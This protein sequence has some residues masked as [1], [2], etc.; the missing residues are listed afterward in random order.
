MD[1]QASYNNELL[2]RVEDISGNA[3][4]LFR[5]Q[6]L[7]PKQ[8]AIF[9][10]LETLTIYIMQPSQR[11][12]YI[13]QVIDALA[14]CEKF[15]KFGDKAIDPIKPHYSARHYSFGMN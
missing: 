15:I 6:Y 13:C 3:E 7:T 2:A 10:D 14:N 8:K 5:D 9:D 4:K 12:D 11:D 1:D